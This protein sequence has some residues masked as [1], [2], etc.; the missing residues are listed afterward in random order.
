MS[1]RAVWGGAQASAK[2]LDTQAKMPKSTELLLVLAA[3]ASLVARG[4]Y[5]T[6]AT[7]AIGFWEKHEHSSS[8]FLRVKTT[9]IRFLAE[10]RNIFHSRERETEFI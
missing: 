10:V 3:G 7:A 9:F 2:H 1:S 6:H 4:A 5:A 8:A